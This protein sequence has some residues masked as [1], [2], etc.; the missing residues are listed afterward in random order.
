MNMSYLDRLK[1][2]GVDIGLNTIIV[3]CEGQRRIFDMADMYEFST[4]G[5]EVTYFDGEGSS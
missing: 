1:E 5:T 4:D 2:E 3:E